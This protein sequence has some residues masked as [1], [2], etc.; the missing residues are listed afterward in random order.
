M[1]KIV[2]CF[3]CLSFIACSDVDEQLVVDES[4]FDSATGQDLR[5]QTV[6][7]TLDTG[8]P[9][10][11]TFQKKAGYTYRITVNTLSGNMDLFGHW[12]RDFKPWSA[13]LESRNPGTMTDVIEFTAKESGPYFAG[14]VATEGG[15]GQIFLEEF[16]P[17]KKNHEIK[18]SCNKCKT[19]SA[20][21]EMVD[22]LVDEFAE[23]YQL[24]DTK[25]TFKIGGSGACI[26]GIGEITCPQSFLD[27]GYVT[28]KL[29]FHELNHAVKNARELGDYIAGDF[30]VC[31]PTIDSCSYVFD[32]T[33]YSCKKCGS[34]ELQAA[35]LE[36]Y[37]F[38]VCSGSTYRFYRQGK[39]SLN[40]DQLADRLLDNQSML[41]DDDISNIWGFTLS[42][43]DL[44]ASVLKRLDVSS[45]KEL[46]WCQQFS[47]YST[48]E[49]L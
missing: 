30:G 9:L 16:E 48:C 23:Y 15:E 29:L 31:G 49:N 32:G 24:G 22:D 2:S 27:A 6:S 35:I 11:G 1:K 39:P 21:Q 38:G 4:T 40:V 26:G 44:N 28:D 43:N 36:G 47:N 42:E 46:F 45:T 17:P 41:S 12:R 14:I 25:I 18:R 34:S 8:K 7:Y 19:Q 3:L 5:Y 13:R 20:C 10:V 33:T 37:Y